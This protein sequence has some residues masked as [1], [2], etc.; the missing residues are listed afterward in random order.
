MKILLISDFG[1]HHTPGGAQRSNDIIIREG[2]SRGHAISVYH[3][4]SNVSIL[5]DNY[6]WIISSNLEVISQTNPALVSSIPRVPNHIR[7]E[8]DSNLYWD[9]SFRKYFWQSCK[10]SFFLT[11]FHHE[12][13]VESFGDIFPN[14]CIVPDPIDKSFEPIY[15]WRA[16][17][18]IGY[19]G[20]MHYLKG[21][22]NFIRYVEDHPDKEFIV[23]AWGDE[24]YESKL[25]SLKNVD[26]R[27]KIPFEQMPEFYSSIEY[28][29]YSPVCK[30]PF[31]R[32]VGEALMCG[33]ELLGDCSNV[34]A[35]RMFYEDRDVFANKC[36]NAASNFWKEIECL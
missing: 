16:R 2:V 23:A 32:A 12:F 21:T 24:K 4:D 14:V 25:K 18:G 1:L 33:A 10:K 22:E 11:K 35:A 17:S 31:C 19:V 9:Q 8:H 28:L 27:W 6:D 29:Y 20:F 3:Y 30:E 5:N 7:L 34:G 26:F 15:N 13:F 36:I